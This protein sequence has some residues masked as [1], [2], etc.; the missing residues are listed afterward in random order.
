MLLLCHYV[1]SVNLQTLTDLHADSSRNIWSSHMY[2]DVTWTHSNSVRLKHCKCVVDHRSRGGTT[3]LFH[4][5][6]RESPGIIT[7]ISDGGIQFS[8]ESSF[9]CMLAH[10]AHWATKRECSYL[11]WV[12]PVPF[13]LWQIQMS[14]VKGDC[15][16][17]LLFI[18]FF[19]KCLKC[20]NLQKTDEFHFTNCSMEHFNM[21]LL[22]MGII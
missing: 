4:Y 2:S 9:L 3:D 5:F 19:L 15:C 14:A 1:V 18:F 21:H 6:S 13:L 7:N 10:L 22:W 11:L 20:L 8:S 16:S 12:T 17:M